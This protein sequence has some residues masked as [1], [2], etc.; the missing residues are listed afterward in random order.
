MRRE[1]LP[2]VTAHSFL[3]CVLVTLLGAA[4]SPSFLLPPPVATADSGPTPVLDG[5]RP[6]LDAGLSI[7]EA[8]LV[9]NRQRCDH[10][11]RCGLI[12]DD[13]QG[14]QECIRALEATWCGPSTWPSHVAKGALRYDALRAQ[15]CAE[16]FSTQ[17]CSEWATLSESC[18]RFLSPRARLGEACYDTFVEC[19]EGVCGGS[20]CPRSCVPRG[21]LGESCR[22]HSDCRVGLY[23]KPSPFAPDVRQ[24][25]AY[26]AL[27]AACASDPECHEDLRC[28]MNQCRE[29]PPPGRECLAGQCS[30]SGY[31]D[32]TVADGGVCSLRKQGGSQC[33]G[34]QC[35]SSM[36]CD[37][38]R[39]VCVPLNSGPGDAC[40][41]AQ[42]C[43][44]GQVCLGLS[45]SMPGS[46]HPP[47][48]EGE[49]CERHLDCEEHLACRRA[50]GGSTCQRR[51]QT[52]EP[53]DSARVCQSSA[54]C[55]ATGCVP[56]PLPGQSCEQTRA[57]RWGLC[58]TLAHD[59]GSVCGTLLSAGQP[60]SQNAQCGSGSC[61]SGFC[62]ALCLP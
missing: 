27:G 7:R 15:T 59:A 53:C 10:L 51:A 23:C 48:Q 41:L 9:L 20:S 62:A 52:G 11:T 17:T 8:C 28:F 55:T 24:C 36:V 31:C 19:A 58:R 16:S 22:V 29:L 34:D 38:F 13:A 30:E 4:C 21:L 14:K 1:L 43:P 2:T 50:D 26:G 12:S 60:C 44:A 57:C 49:R 33:T 40:T 18:T 3:K 56:L 6:G 47:L 25:A 42:R 61:E 32:F 46:C 37:P 5:G 39:A 35:E 45:G 54:V